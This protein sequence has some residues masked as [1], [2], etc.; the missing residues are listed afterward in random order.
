MYSKDGVSKCKVTVGIAGPVSTRTTDYRAIPLSHRGTYASVFIDARHRP[1]K[2]SI[3]SRLILE[4]G[5]SYSIPLAVTQQTRSLVNSIAQINTPIHHT[6]LGSRPE[7][8]CFNRA[9]QTLQQVIRDLKSILIF[10]LQKAAI[11]EHLLL[12][13]SQYSQ[14]PF[15]S[16][17]LRY[18]FERT[19]LSKKSLASRSE[20]LEKTR[21][22]ALVGAPNP[23]VPIP[24]KTKPIAQIDVLFTTRGQHE[25]APD[26]ATGL[27]KGRTFK[28]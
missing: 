27:V 28:A 22:V 18:A 17:V 11:K 21:Y 12:P 8:V 4:Q 5:S 24:T 13:Q 25:K 3:R 1:R 6:A 15:L 10:V 26:I 23:V 19:N 2:I 14:R 20:F 9:I 16:Q 7:T